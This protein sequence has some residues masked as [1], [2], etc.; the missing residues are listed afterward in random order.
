MNQLLHLEVPFYHA[1]IYQSNT[2]YI[3]EL[4]SARDYGGK[5]YFPKDDGL[6]KILTPGCED[7]GVI[8]EFIPQ[9]WEEKGLSLDAK[10]CISRYNSHLN[11]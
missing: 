9:I 2:G 6:A 10:I 4:Q 1:T 3:I 7:L 5:F 8:G 11:S